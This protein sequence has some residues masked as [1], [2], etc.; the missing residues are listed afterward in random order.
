MHIDTGTE[1]VLAEIVDGVGV[2]TLNQPTRRNALHPEMYDGVPRALDRFLAD[3]G[4]G[5]ILIT[6]PSTSR[7][8]KPC[9]W[10]A[11]E[12]SALDEPT[13][14]APPSRPGWPGPRPNARVPTSF[15]AT[16]DSTPGAPTNPLPTVRDTVVSFCLRTLRVA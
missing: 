9:R 2:V 16:P 6:R 1:T 8:R 3:D 12:W 10:R 15:I 11:N 13:T 14:T 7:W 5:C 4:V